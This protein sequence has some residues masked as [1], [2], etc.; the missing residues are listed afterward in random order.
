MV[1]FLSSRFV[2]GVLAVA[3]E[4]KERE[5]ARAAEDGRELSEERA[6]QLTVKPEE[7]AALRHR[8]ALPQKTP[9][10]N[11]DQAW[12]YGWPRVKIR[13]IPVPEEPPAA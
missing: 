6:K 8:K 5:I 9:P 11:L 13:P 3:G 10:C 2:P 1:V 12:R 7:A 4:Y